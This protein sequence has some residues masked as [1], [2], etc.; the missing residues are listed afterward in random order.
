MVKIIHPTLVIFFSNGKI[1]TVTNII[2]IVIITFTILLLEV[3][4]FKKLPKLIFGT[5]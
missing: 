3:F 4:L 2:N 1:K 5:I